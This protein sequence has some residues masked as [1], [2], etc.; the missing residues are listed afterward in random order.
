MS[1]KEKI[2]LDRRTI[3]ILTEE[4]IDSVQGAATTTVDEPSLAVT[5]CITTIATACGKACAD[6]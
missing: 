5:T 6:W 1:K 2:Q 3:R 4:A